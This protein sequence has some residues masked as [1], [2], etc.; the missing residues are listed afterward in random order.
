MGAVKSKIKP[1]ML[2]SL[3]KF[4]GVGRFIDND[5]VYPV[6]TPRNC[7]RFSMGLVPKDIQPT[8]SLVALTEEWFSEHTYI[9]NLLNDYPV[10][11]GEVL[12]L[13]AHYKFREDRSYA[14]IPIVYFC[15][16]KK[17]YKA[18]W[19]YVTEILLPSGKKI[20]N[21]DA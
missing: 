11:T 13:N 21:D 14:I 12:I 9:K 16:T 15:P 8:N 1:P 10:E 17:T 4:F 2:F 7:R 6:Y 18:A 19:W 20:D 3:D 5:V